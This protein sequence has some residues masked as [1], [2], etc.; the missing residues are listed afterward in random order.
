[1]LNI[2][3]FFALQLAEIPRL[4]FGM[5]L[6]LSI[7]KPQKREIVMKTK[8]NVLLALSLT[9]LMSLTLTMNQAPKSSR[10]I[11][12]I[13]E[14]VQT[15][16]S[17]R[18]K[19]AKNKE[20]IKKK[21]ERLGEID[22]LIADYDRQDQAANN[23][24]ECKEE[25]EKVTLEKQTLTDEVAKLEKD[26]KD[27]EVLAFDETNIELEQT[28]KELAEA[29]KRE[30]LAKKEQE[31]KEKKDSV[32]CEKDSQL[33]VV[34]SLFA[35]LVQ[36]QQLITSMFMQTQ[37]LMFTQMLENHYF[38]LSYNHVSDIG[39]RSESLNSILGMTQNFYMMPAYAQPGSQVQSQMQVNNDASSVLLDNPNV[40]NIQ[41]P[42]N[43]ADVS[44]NPMYV[45]SFNGFMDP[46]SGLPGGA[47]VPYQF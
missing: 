2:F 47:A 45:P 26:Q 14:E 31:E 17:A 7:T 42:I 46:A 12:S 9:G 44:R 18:E 4:L 29:K 5:G 28:K 43:V 16:L 36:Q 35:Q 34:T 1:M 39:Q 27:L 3:P 37:M 41:A 20:D 11:A 21:K 8:S 19:L 40:Q 38:H 23:P 6:V 24:N 33:P 25:R 13:Q 10:S 30:E 32:T 22:K 15:E